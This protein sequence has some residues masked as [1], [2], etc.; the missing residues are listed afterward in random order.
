MGKDAALVTSGGA[1]VLGVQMYR[2]QMC[3]I[4]ALD[5]NAAGFSL[6]SDRFAAISRTTL[7]TMRAES[8]ADICAT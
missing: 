1:G 2:G 3:A 5:G 6:N 7:V 4:F 8:D